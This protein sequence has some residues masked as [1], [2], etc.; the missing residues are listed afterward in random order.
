MFQNSRKITKNILRSIQ[1][2]NSRIKVSL[3]EFPF[4]PF[5]IEN[6]QIDVT[7]LKVYLN[8]TILSNLDCHNLEKLK[9]K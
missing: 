6:T 4:W 2:K 7:T 5:N 8:V 3:M 1:F 9:Q